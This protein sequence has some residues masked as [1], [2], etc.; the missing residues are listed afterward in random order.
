MVTSR[1]G[2]AARWRGLRCQW[3]AIAAGMGGDGWGKRHPSSTRV[4]GIVSAVGWVKRADASARKQ[5]LIARN[6]SSS[7]CVVAE[8]ILGPAPLDGLRAAGIGFRGHPGTHSTHP[9]KIPRHPMREASSSRRKTPCKPHKAAR[10][11]G[12]GRAPQDPPPT[13]SDGG[14]PKHT[15]LPSCRQIATNAARRGGGRWGA[16]SR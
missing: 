7:R 3:P 1:S 16:G 11:A 8:S 15:A 14:N 4:Q 6:P 5:A 9:T 2:V 10:A 12:L 13:S